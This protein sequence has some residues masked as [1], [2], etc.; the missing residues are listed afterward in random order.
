MSDVLQEMAEAVK[1]MEATIPSENSSNQEKAQAAENALLRHLAR[2]AVLAGERDKCLGQIEQLKQSIQQLNQVLS[3]ARQQR[4]ELVKA[5]EEAGG[6][7]P[8]WNLS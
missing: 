3:Q 2:E 8:T 6:K 1:A 5:V 7:L 4:D